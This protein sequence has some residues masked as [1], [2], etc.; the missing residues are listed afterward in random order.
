M[1]LLLSGYSFSNKHNNYN[2]LK[3]LEKKSFTKNNIKEEIEDL[4]D[5]IYRMNIFY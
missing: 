4:R 2:L 3:N 5:F 1:H